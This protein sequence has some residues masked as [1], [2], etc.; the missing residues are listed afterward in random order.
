MQEVNKQLAMI[1]ACFGLVLLLLS[2]FTDLLAQPWFVFVVALWIFVFS[3]CCYRLTALFYAQNTV[4]KLIQ[5]DKTSLVCLS[6]SGFFNCTTGPYCFSID[7]IDRIK[8]EQ[9]GFS[10]YAANT[11]VY[12]TRLPGSKK[13]LRDYF[14]SLLTSQEKLSVTID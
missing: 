4:D 13:L 7:S 3:S 10:I 12:S 5:R 6:L 9:D 11:C 2:L 14:N 1:V 8:C